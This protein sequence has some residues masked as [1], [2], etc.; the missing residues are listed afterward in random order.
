MLDWTWGPIQFY[1]FSPRN[2]Y[3]GPLG[4]AASE[5]ESDDAEQEGNYDFVERE[6][7]QLARQ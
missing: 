3:A 7:V 2:R 1:I 4:L 5:P 6:R